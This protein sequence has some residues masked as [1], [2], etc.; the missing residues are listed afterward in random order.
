M[1]RA[2]KCFLEKNS[3]MYKTNVLQNI[4]KISRI[5]KKTDNA[6]IC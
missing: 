1:I 3:K 5:L 6:I 2:R 4:L